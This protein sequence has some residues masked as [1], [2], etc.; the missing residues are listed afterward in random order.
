MLTEALLALAGAGGT[1]I[2]QAACSDAWESVKP[3]IV[4]IWRRGDNR[5]QELI[6]ES[7]DVTHAEMEPLVA[8]E[9]DAKVE[10]VAAAW[11]SRLE[12]LLNTDPA[13][14]QELQELV[15]HLTQQNSTSSRTE[16]GAGSTAA[17][18][19]SYTADRG[20]VA[21]AQIHGSVSISNPP[22]PGGKQA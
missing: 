10:E 22:Q 15:L 3:R 4:R 11:T 17:G 13:A 8:S 6:S 9:V 19:V 14:A 7:L 20:S 18:N 21:A 16:L 5:R 1:A 2:A 12:E